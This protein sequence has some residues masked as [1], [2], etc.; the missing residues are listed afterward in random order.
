MKKVRPNQSS[1]ISRKTFTVPIIFLIAFLLFWEVAVYIS[2]IE[3]WILPAP[4]KVFV[5]LGDMYPLLLEHSLVTLTAA[6]AGLLT[7]ILIAFILAVLIDFS[8]L[9]KKGVYPLLV[10]SQTIPIVFIAPLLIIWFGY[11]ILPKIVVVT[12]VCFFPVV[13]S[14][15]EGMES[16]DPEMV[17][18]LKVMGATRAQIIKKV[19]IPGALPSLFAGLKI[20]GTYAVM[21]AVI[22]EWVGA[23][24]GLGV[25]TMRAYYAYQLDRVFAGIIVISIVSLLIFAL[26]EILARFI[27]PWYYSERSGQK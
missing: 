3:S 1:F 11:G 20:A 22:G 24:K 25:F 7:A 9:L 18:L 16:T 12:L 27:M 19:R 21:G 26:I 2:G 13:V 23:S 4:S 6:F 8:P 10:V 5:T 17:D 14:M 15:V